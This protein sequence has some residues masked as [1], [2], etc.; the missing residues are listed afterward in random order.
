MF[1]I[2]SEPFNSNNFC[3]LAKETLCT[4]LKETLYTWCLIF[5]ED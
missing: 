4:W 1:S 2:E 5:G 3:C